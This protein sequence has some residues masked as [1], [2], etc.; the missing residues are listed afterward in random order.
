VAFRISY[1]RGSTVGTAPATLR[2]AGLGLAALFLV[3]PRSLGAAGIPSSSPGGASAPTLEVE[4]PLASRIRLEVSDRVRGEFWSYF[5]T[6]DSGTA[7][8]SDYRFLGNR[9]Q[10]GVRV[11]REPVEL[12]AQLQHSL[13]WPAPENAPGPGGV[14][15][16]NTRRELQQ[17][18]IF[19]QGWVRWKKA[20][21]VPGLSLVAGRQ[22][23]RDGLEAPAKDPALQWV[24]KVRIAERL[25]G[26]FDYTRG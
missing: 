26:P 17:E 11:N 9:F 5:R 8:N 7:P 24:Q 21:T 10:L 6:A 3:T 12:F 16:L 4:G 25:I 13:V 15:F 2:L 18:A 20:F 23:Y 22:L 1:G 19:R 14:Y